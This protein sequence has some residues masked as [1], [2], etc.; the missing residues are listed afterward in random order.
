VHSLVLSLGFQ[1]R[2][3]V[4]GFIPSKSII[5]KESDEDVGGYGPFALGYARG[6]K[7]GVVHL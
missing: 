3:Y 2:L 5:S 4:F 1:E 7:A 6:R